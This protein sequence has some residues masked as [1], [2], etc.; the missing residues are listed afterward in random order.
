MILVQK[1]D[2][3][4]R[5]CIDYRRMNGVTVKDAHPILKVDEFL[6]ALEGTIYFTKLDF[7]S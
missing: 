1:K 6:D 4:S 3:G 5:L 2:E 7:E